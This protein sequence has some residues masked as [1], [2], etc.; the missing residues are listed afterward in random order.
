MKKILQIGLKD[1]NGIDIRLGDV[2][3]A[4]IKDKDGNISGCT[5]EV[6]TFEP[7]N[8]EVVLT[9]LNKKQEYMDIPLDSDCLEV[10]E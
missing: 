7:Q 9:P 1:K 2:V 6:V 5:K 8:K 3:I 4:C 10:I